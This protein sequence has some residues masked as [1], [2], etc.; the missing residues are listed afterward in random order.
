[1]FNSEKLQCKCYWQETDYV[2]YNIMEHQA[3][4][5]SDGDLHSLL[6]KDVLVAI[7]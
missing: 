4:I 5:K 7:Q 2:N 1:M 3:A 6:C